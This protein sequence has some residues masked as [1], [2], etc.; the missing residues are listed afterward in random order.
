MY[1]F[2]KYLIVLQR[3]VVKVNWRFD[4]KFYIHVFLKFPKVLNIKYSKVIFDFLETFPLVVSYAW[5]E[6]ISMN[7]LQRKIKL[8]TGYFSVFI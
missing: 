3:G 8:T 1:S 7:S 4:V 6:Q 5:S 2:V